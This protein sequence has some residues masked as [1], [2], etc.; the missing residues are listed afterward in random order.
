MSDQGPLK[1]YWW[2]EKPNFGD[3]ISADVVAHIAGRKVEWA[4]PKD[5]DLFAVGSLSTIV[6]ANCL[7]PREA[8][9]APWIWGTGMAAP[10]RLGFLDNVNIAALRGPLTANFMQ[11][12]DA[13]L[14][15]PGIFAADLAGPVEKTEQIGIMLHIS[16]R[17]RGPE[18]R[19]IRRDGRFRFIDP[20]ADDHLS[21]VRALGACRHVVSSSLHGLILADAYGVPNTWLA[22]PDAQRISA[23]FKFYDYGL[24][25][26]RAFDA[27]I[28]SL[29]VDDLL[30][31]ADAGSPDV[32]DGIMRSKEALSAAFP[33]ELKAN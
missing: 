13:A 16:H 7:T 1:L 11:T 20:A 26:G 32:Q 3:Q 4:A 12:R 31:A 19:A 29:T 27:P 6:R 22:R 8:G 33:A 28:T 25:V 14:G 21:V 17:F 15:D 2:N 23:N 9:P 24:S 10:H 5:C 30:R 18:R